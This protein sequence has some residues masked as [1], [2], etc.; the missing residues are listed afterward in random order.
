METQEAMHQAIRNIGIVPVIKIDSPN[1]ALPLGKAL[2]EGGLPI[3]E[4]TFRTDAGAEG[5]RILRTELPGMLVGAGTIVSAEQAERAVDSGAQFIVSPGYSDSVVGWCL[6]HEVPVYP[7]VIDPSQIQMAMARGLTVLKFFPAE[8]SGGIDM[9]DALSGPFPTIRFM[10]TG[11]IGMHNLASYLRKSYIVACGGSWMVKNELI[12]AGRWDEISR[13]G[14]E[15]VLAVHGFTFAHLGINGEAG[16]SPLRIIEVLGAML[17]PVTEGNASVFAGESIEIMKAPY[18][19]THGH[20]G[21]RTWD[22][23][24]ALH[25]LGR[26]GLEMDETTAKRDA[27]GT[28]T[29]TYLKGEIGG[30]ALHLVRAK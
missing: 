21:L 3:A 28:L 17:Q 18:K 20:I 6:D 29:V 4:V 25:Y 8:A 5:I 13:L 16:T 9:L 15:A 2:I 24:R 12:N 14:R 22:I 7:G 23:E 19:G 27:K 26:F 10:P 11:G 30:F 1:Q